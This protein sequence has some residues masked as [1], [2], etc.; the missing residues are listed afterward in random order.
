MNE[1]QVN[2]L[3]VLNLLRLKEKIRLKY[4]IEYFRFERYTSVKKA[5][6][7]KVISLSFEF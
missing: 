3:W 2:S 7:D 5:I 6:T 1:I 4:L